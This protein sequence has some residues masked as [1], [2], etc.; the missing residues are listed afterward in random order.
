MRE[1]TSS[2]GIVVPPMLTTPR[3]PPGP[4]P[5]RVTDFP[6]AG[7]ERRALAFFLDYA[8]VFLFSHAALFAIGM[9]LGIFEMEMPGTLIFSASFRQ[10]LSWA[11]YLTT[12]YHYYGWCYSRDGATFGK[13]LVGI[14]VIQHDPRKYP[15]YMDAFLRE[16]VGKILLAPLL[17]IG[18][19]L[20]TK[21]GEDH[22]LI[23]DRMC[24][25]RVVLKKR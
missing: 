7:L 8:V 4:E 11:V 19:F 18:F 12:I 2:G 25:T 23:H 10:Y 9:L 15:D 16:A 3:P 20:A 21:A 14:A 6:D 13:R 1:L 24:G 17:P 5:K 22:R